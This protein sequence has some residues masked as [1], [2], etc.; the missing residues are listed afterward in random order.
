MML[1]PLLVTSVT[2]VLCLFVLVLALVLS[3]AKRDVKIEVNLLP[4]NL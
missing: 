4:L 3:S 2:F 1:T